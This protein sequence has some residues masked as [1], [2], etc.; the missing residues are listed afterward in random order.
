M[1]KWEFFSDSEVEGLQDEFIAKLVIA[2]RKTIELDPEKKGVPFIITSGLRTPSQNQ[3]VIGAV[4]D[5][6]HLKCLA[7]DLRVR[8]SRETALII[9]ACLYAGIKRR[10]IY[11]DSY[12]NPRHI[13]VD[14][15]P[16][17]IDEV[18]FIKREE[19]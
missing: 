7:V 9:D 15:D 17:K 12:F 16:E 19:N 5:S 6:S 1:S 10:G 13:H 4:A 14:I 8:S 2:R 11:V 18:I 3:S